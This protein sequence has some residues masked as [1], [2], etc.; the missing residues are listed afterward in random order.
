MFC[1]SI[2]TT[3]AIIFSRSFFSLRFISL[4]SVEIVK[5][6][7]FSTV[8][9]YRSFVYK[10][11]FCICK[12]STICCSP[13]HSIFF[14]SRFLFTRWLLSLSLNLRNDAHFLSIFILPSTDLYWSLMIMPTN[15]FACTLFSSVDWCSFPIS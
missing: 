11:C 8:A 4:V 9:R 6:S 15:S 13:L 3:N 5:W 14:L 10:H 2:S 7:K 1:F 12:S